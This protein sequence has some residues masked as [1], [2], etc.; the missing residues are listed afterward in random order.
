MTDYALRFENVS[1]RYPRGSGAQMQLRQDI[2]RFFRSS[3]DGRGSPED[4]RSALV[5]AKGMY[6]PVRLHRLPGRWSVARV[7]QPALSPPAPACRTRSPTRLRAACRSTVSDCPP[8]PPAHH[9]LFQRALP[10]RT[11]P[12]P[13]AAL[14][15]ASKI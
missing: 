4:C 5:V 6:E 9:L 13:S 3:R 8:A 1:K 12:A 11:L 7:F 10:S 15:G 2:V 14:Q